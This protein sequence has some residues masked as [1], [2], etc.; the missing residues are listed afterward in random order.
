MKRLKEL[1]ENKKLTQSQLSKILN[2]STS[3]VGMYE[4][5]RRFPDENI[6]KN[7]AHFFNVS[8]DYLLDNDLQ[9]KEPD[10]IMPGI[11]LKNDIELSADEEELI[12]K[13]RQLPADRQ[14]TVKLILDN[15]VS[16]VVQS[17]EEKRRNA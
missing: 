9:K 11:S 13:Y 2:I 1:R 6:L 16:A 14:E 4:Q 7:I 15:Q 17:E 3:A 5:G 10:S 8:I 12:K